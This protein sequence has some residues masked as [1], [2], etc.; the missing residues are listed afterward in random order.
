[1]PPNLL[2]EFKPN[3][4]FV[5]QFQV[6]S[7]APGGAFGLALQSIGTQIQLAAVD[8][9]ANTLEIFTLDPPISGGGQAQQGVMPTT[10]VNSIMQST[11]TSSSTSAQ[12]SSSSGQTSVIDMV[13]QDLNAEVT[14]IESQLLAMDPHLSMGVQM[15]NSMLEMVETDI[16]GHPIG[17]M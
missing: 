10:M 14:M 8:D 1:V 15:F 5:G 6:D 3:G 9:D 13:L 17:G 4:Q 12:Q 16:A 7:G 11:T 2:L